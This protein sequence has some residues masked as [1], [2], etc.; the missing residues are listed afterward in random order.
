VNMSDLPPRLHH[1]G[2][3]VAEIHTGMTSFV[4]SLG[5]AWDGQV[6]E[7]P[8]QR[9]KV[10]FLTVRPGEAQ[11]EL[12]EPAGEDSP[13]MRFLHQKGGGMHHLCYEVPD[14]DRSL[15]D[16]KG[17]GALIAKRPKPAVA[18]AGRRIAW[19]L[20]AEKLLIELLEEET[21]R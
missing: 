7:D 3:V 18:F 1:I 12:V 5:A 9:V 17:R 13:V 11:I 6:F 20:T 4:R 15:M 21:H 14:L 16:W 19:I 10:A 2:F 8:H